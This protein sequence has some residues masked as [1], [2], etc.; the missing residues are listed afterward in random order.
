MCCPEV[1]HEHWLSNLEATGWLKHIKIVLAGALKIADKVVFTSIFG[2]FEGTT[3]VHKENRKSSKHLKSNFC[4]KAIDGWYDL[5][6]NDLSNLPIV[7]PRLRIERAQ[8]WFTA[9]MGGIGQPS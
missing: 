5:P 2:T 6:C 7:L 8:C 4:Q 1:D 9:A 3:H